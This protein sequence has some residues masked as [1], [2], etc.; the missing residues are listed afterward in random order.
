[1]RE[2]K[3]LNYQRVNQLKRR[4]KGGKILDPPRTGKRKRMLR[5]IISIVSNRGQSIAWSPG[6]GKSTLLVG[7]REGKR[8]RGRTWVGKKNKKKT[9]QM[10]DKKKREG[11]KDFWRK[12]QKRGGR[13][14]GG[15]PQR[16]SERERIDPFE[17]K[18]G[19]RKERGGRRKRQYPIF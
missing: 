4:R 17:I 1:M 3:K 8:L 9:R 12:A 13:F 16:V 10:C 6:A 15:A 19:R 11:L 7:E 18:E 2:E 14:Q 5:K